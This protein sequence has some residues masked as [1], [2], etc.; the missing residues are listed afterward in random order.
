[1]Y[2]YVLVLSGTAICCRDAIGRDEVSASAT[3]A[4]WS[5]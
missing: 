5:S 3:E 4:Y 2:Y 1:M